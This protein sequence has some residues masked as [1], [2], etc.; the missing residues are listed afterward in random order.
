[1]EQSAQWE[2]R[3]ADFSDAGNSN[4][5][6]A[7]IYGNLLH[8]PALG[9]LHWT[10]QKWEEDETA[11][12][13]YG[14]QYTDAMLQDAL[15][16]YGTAA[17]DGA[18]SAAETKAKRYLAHAQ[19]SRSKNSIRAMLEL[20]R[21]DLTVNLEELDAD[22]FT[23][24]MPGG[25]VNIKED[26]FIPHTPKCLC[27]KITTVNWGNQG[28]DVWKHFLQD[29]TCGDER[30]E[31][32]L[33]QVA[34]MIVTGKVFTETAVILYGGGR[35]GKS[36]FLNC[37][38]S[39]L[40]SYA[41]TFPADLLTTNARQ[42]KGAAF[43]S[44]QGLRL[45]AAGELEQGA[46]LSA[47]TLKQLCST[48]PVLGERKYYAPQSFTPTHTLVLCSN[49]KPRVSSWDNGTWRRLT[50]VP[51]HADFSGQ[52]ER[53]NYAAELVEKA[54]PAILRWAVEGATEYIKNG[55]QLPPCE[56][57][58]E[59]CEEYKQQED[60]LQA[61]LEECCTISSA[62]RVQSSV[63][64][65]AYQQHSQRTGEYC[66]RSVEFA[67]AMEAKGFRKM[68]LHGTKYWAGL[69]LDNTVQMPNSYANSSY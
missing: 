29:I 40:G 23:L 8:C 9:W 36:T 58:A 31:A 65:S 67:E 12:L 39:V 17:Q 56:A 3:P 25:V 44:L 19:K 53:K 10:G 57:V 24:N 51:F 41:G 15:T 55:G 43:A 22:G 46:R 45:A 13:D 2:F 11:A 32:F 33:Q 47:S 38:Y 18:G 34:G 16:E 1:M 60:Q 42:N 62:A 54:G 20:A 52:K 14:K 50:L 49:Y 64:Y 63:L 61:F 7:W 35:N 21:P 37:L 28:A 4:A 5:F 26:T 66:R 30:L 48:D 27:T 68:N 59:A 6:A 69:S